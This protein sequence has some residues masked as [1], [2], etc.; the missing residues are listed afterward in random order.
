MPRCDR[1]DRWFRTAQALEQHKDDSSMHHI[2]YDCN[3]DFALNTALIQHFT[4]SPRHHY[5][6]SCDEHF[7]DWDDLYDHYDEAHYYCRICNQ[8]YESE[9]G[10]HEHRRIVHADEYCVPCKR[11]FRDTNALRHHQ[12]S[13]LH[14][15]RTIACPMRGCS[16]SF[17]SRAA[18]VLHLE[19]GGCPSRITRDMV[20][21]I[22]AKLDKHGVLT[23]SARLLGS[24]SGGSG[25]GQE[26]VTV[27]GAWATA[28]AWN[29]ARYECYLCH[30]TFAA[31]PDLNQHLN[32]PAHAS[33]AYRCP[34]AWRGCGATFRTLSGF[35]QHVESEQCGV[36]R[37]KRDR[38]IDGLP[39]GGKLLL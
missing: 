26:T 29:G 37:F 4:Q 5:C 19:S 20:N 8:V 18:L 21:R 10:L 39:K 6:R 9:P 15:G 33:R 13:T 35:C 7:D 27:T 17:V 32:S 23:D 2:C 11:M 25:N 36:H 22:V 30:R 34:G 1:C 14:Q 31:L 38:F 28:R 12:R 3:K 24:G 16:R